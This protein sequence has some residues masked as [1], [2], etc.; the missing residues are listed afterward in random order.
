MSHSRILQS[1]RGRIDHHQLFCLIL[2]HPDIA[3]TLLND[4]Y[5]YE[6]AGRLDP[7]QAWYGH[8]WS[9][10]RQPSFPEPVTLD[11][12]R[13]PAETFNTLLRQ[14]NTIFQVKTRSRMSLLSLKSIL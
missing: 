3:G 13:V 7:S 2:S 12:T 11:T 9:P 5:V 14:L 4:V 6:L 10:G 8:P 1:V